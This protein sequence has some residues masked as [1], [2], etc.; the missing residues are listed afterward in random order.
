M[1]AEN[2][3]NDVM[4]INDPLDINSKKSY[5]LNIITIILQ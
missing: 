3:N 5:I 4:N 2:N 1:A